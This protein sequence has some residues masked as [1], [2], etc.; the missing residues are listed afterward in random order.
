MDTLFIKADQSFLF[1]KRFQI[2]MKVLVYFFFN[3]QMELTEPITIIAIL[4]IIFQNHDLWI[5]YPS[6]DFKN[7]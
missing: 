6:F 3:I 1:R 5:F 2:K 7:F 4:K